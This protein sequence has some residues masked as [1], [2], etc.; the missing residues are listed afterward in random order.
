MLQRTGR[1]MRFG[2]ARARQFRNLFLDTEKT[3]EQYFACIKPI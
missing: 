1:R 3:K 2:A